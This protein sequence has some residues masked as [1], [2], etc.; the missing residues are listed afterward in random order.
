MSN[1]ELYE[2]F[3]FPSLI[4]E[5][6][7][8]DF[9]S[10]RNDL[11]QWI[12]NYQSYTEGVHISNRGGWQSPDN[13][14]EEESFLFYR[15]YIWDHIKIGTSRYNAD[16]SLDNM[17]INVNTKGNYNTSHTHPGA[18]L[19]GVFWIS[20]PENSG[21]LMFESPNDHAQ[22]RLFELL[23]SD[24][25][26]QFNIFPTYHFKPNEGRMVIFP[27]DIRHYVDPNESDEERISIAFNLML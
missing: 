14:F 6:F 5:V 27:P 1:I 24:I 15:K 18:I 11:I 16:F 17:W 26:D 7:C 22:Y 2:Y 4:T 10:I 25:K 12:K 13:F 3:V 23:D 19:S 21:N 9:G 20:T 8:E